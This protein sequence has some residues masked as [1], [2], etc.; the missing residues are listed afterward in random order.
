MAESLK[1]SYF[2]DQIYLPLLKTNKCKYHVIF[3]IGSQI[4]VT[5]RQNSIEQVQ[6]IHD[7]SLMIIDSE[8]EYGYEQMKAN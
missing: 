6:P 4:N 3:N 2:K 7:G 5:M 8:M 1:I